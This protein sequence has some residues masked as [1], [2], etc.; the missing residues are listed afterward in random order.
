[1]ARTA[2]PIPAA[3]SAPPVAAGTL[4]PPIRRRAVLAL[5]TAAALTA[6]ATLGTPAAGV[7]PDLVRL[8][9]FMALMKGGFAALALAACWYRLARPAAPWR[10]LVYLA[11]PALTAG[12]ALALWRLAGPGLAAGVLHLGLLALLAA[13]LTDGDF[14]PGDGL[15][16]LRGRS[17]GRP[18]GRPSSPVQGAPARGR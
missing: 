3:T 10:E 6:G 2:E 1:M 18:P 5:A 17:P 13:A 12:G 15:S 14:L 11:A 4:A 7:E 9:R 8:M 16:R